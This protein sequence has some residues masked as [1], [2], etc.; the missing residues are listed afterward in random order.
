MQ[1]PTTVDV[2]D[3]RQ[4]L[5]M[6]NYS[7]FQEILDRIE[8][9][10]DKKELFPRPSKNNAPVV[11]YGIILVFESP[12]SFHYYACQR[13]TTIEFS[14]IVKC[15]PRKDKLFEY[16]SNL[17]EKERELLVSESHSVLWDDLLLDEKDNFGETKERVGKIFE[18]YAEFLPEL[19]A[20]TESIAESPPYEFTKGRH[21]SSDK[22]SLATA[23]R[24]L[25]EEGNID[26]G[27]SVT[28][29]E[30]ISI[31]DIFTGTDGVRYQTYYYVVK[32]DY[33]YEPESRYVDNSIGEY[34]ISD[35]MTDA[36]WI[37]IPKKINLKVERFKTPLPSRLERCLF[38]VHKNLCNR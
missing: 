15:G 12:T 29:Y 33:M 20:L 22:T 4:P 17:T 37:E 5:S 18:A 31:S 2:D 24:E 25:K 36:T 16:L 30:D 38:E 14:E 13:R 8:E 11:S 26:L 10:S 34:C 7:H 23:V 1:D 3:E 32:S 6:Q 35:D 9:P 21:S 19:I 28:L 27:H